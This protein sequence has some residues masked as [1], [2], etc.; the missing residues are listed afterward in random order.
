MQ[1]TRK[2]PMVKLTKG[3]L[4]R[5]ELLFAE[6]DREAAEKLLRE[7]CGSNLPGNMPSS[8]EGI[9]RIRFA[10]LKLSDGDLRLLA[11]AI[12]EAN[13]DW[14]DVLVFADF[15]ESTT[16]HLDWMPVKRR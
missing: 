4:E 16:A 10:V 13:M 14:R 15:A 3:T 6:E 7:K 5:I 2:H 1:D 12:D 8:Q 11:S 9:E